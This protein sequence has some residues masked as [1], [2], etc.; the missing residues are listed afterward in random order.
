MIFTRREVT[1]AGNAIPGKVDG[2]KTFGFMR[3][4]HFCYGCA[5]VRCLRVVRIVRT[6][7]RTLTA[8][9]FCLST[10]SVPAWHTV[11]SPLPLR[12]LLNVLRII[13]FYSLTVSTRNIFS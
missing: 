11:H 9:R 4:H 1:W 3:V 6:R 10:R 8:F 2:H 5:R 7:T 12:P 13:L